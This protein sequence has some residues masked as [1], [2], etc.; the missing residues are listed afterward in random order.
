M[1][2]PIKV[3][4]FST[5]F[6]STAR[7]VHGIFVESRLRHLIETNQIEVRVVAPVPWFPSTS[8]FF[9][10]WAQ[11]AKTPSNDFYH[12]F[13]VE[14]PRY[15]IIPKF[16]MSLVPFLIALFCLPTIIKIYKEYKFDLIDAHYYYPDGVAAAIISKVFRKPLVITARG[17][18]INLIPKYIIPRILIKW[19]AKTTNVSIAVCQALAN[20][21][22]LLGVSSNSIYVLQNGVD[23]NLFHPINPEIAREKLGIDS[24]RWLLSV[25][26]LTER[27]GHDIA[28]RALVQLTD[29]KLVLIGEGELF[30]YLY[31]LADELGVS[32]RVKFIGSVSQNSLAYW[33]SA[34]DALV[35]CSSRE[36]WANVLLESMACGTPVIATSIWGT[37][38]IVRDPD[39][40]RLMMD[41]TPESLVKCVHDLFDHYP[42]R[43]VVRKYAEHFSWVETT[44]GQLN[45]F[46]KIIK[47]E[48]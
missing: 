5:L 24:G 38:E 30:K 11:I 12:N 20:Q 13:I 22:K 40:G 46:R 19:A 16:G 35:L 7:P 2:R 31:N 9:G 8:S 29:F 42:Q 32:N 44:N 25:G 3:L 27:K 14:Y 48:S 47:C 10:R 17:T 28:I 21:L 36:G 1:K 39:V 15:P 33:Y 18:D 4:L 26:W 41:R 37:P 23:L 45:I 6:P 34:V 43:S